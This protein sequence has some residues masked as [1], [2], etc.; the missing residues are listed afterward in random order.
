M[1]VCVMIM[2]VQNARAIVPGTAQVVFC[3]R[4][5]PFEEDMDEECESYGE[6]EKNF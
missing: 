2:R 4:Y 5:L 1:L 6:N 3:F